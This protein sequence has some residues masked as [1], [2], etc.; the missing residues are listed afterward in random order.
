MAHYALLDRNNTVVK[1]IVGSDENAGIYDWEL[2]YTHEHRL[3]CK[4]TSYNTRAGVHQLGGTPFRKN[5]ANPGY[6]YSP[7]LDAFIPPNSYTGWQL[8]EETCQWEAPVP[9]P[10]TGHQYEWDNTQQI[11]LLLD[12]NV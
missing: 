9:M 10:Q 6:T 12:Q 2:Y 4:R 8:N 7:T 11:W 5:Y 1:V 3:K